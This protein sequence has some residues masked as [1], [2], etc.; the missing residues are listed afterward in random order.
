[1][2]LK[3]FFFKE[4]W[5]NIYTYDEHTTNM[6]VITIV[7]PRTQTLNDLEFIGEHIYDVH[8]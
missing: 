6:I 7:G 1:M 2:N 3:E 4:K 5:L 8:V